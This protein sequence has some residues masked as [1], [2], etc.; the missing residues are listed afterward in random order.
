M[1]ITIIGGGLAGL[2][3]AIECAERG[4]DV[5]L[6]EA[7]SHLGGRAKSTK[8]EYV[9]NHGPHVVYGNGELWRWLS[10]RGLAE[11][12]TKAPMRGF[13]VRHRGTV[14]RTP[15][16]VA[17]KAVRQLRRTDAPDDLSLRAWVDRE[18]G[19]AVADMASRLCHVFTFHHDPGSLAASFVTER[20][21]RTITW[22]TVRYVER[23][24]GA[25]VDRL[26]Q[27]ATSLGAR[28]ETRSKVD[29]LPTDGPVIVAT[30]LGAARALLG[31]DSIRWPG[32]RTAFVDLG[33]RSR[34]GDP[35]VVADLDAGVFLER[36]SLPDPTLAPAG[37]G[38]VQAQ[39]GLRDDETLDDGVR[40]IEAV[41]DAAL[42]HWRERETWCRRFVLTDASGAL[43]PPG[44]TWRDRPAIDRGDG[45]FLC[46]DMVAAPGLLGEVSVTSAVA[47]ATSACSHA[48]S[49]RPWTAASGA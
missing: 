31:D 19:P 23:G 41:F 32:A 17:A 28:I 40:T 16:L 29:A 44:T 10:A 49:R 9:A 14:R 4:E 2:V 22:P 34:R 18:A 46:G 12:A 33:L 1:T 8:G 39:V 30:E 15:P 24:W 43:D 7:Q 48:G 37:H 45:V 36:Y 25:M 6:H 42:P 26:A 5:V 20:A 11:P 27:R 38:L 21:R 35:F 13:R 3:A 47:A